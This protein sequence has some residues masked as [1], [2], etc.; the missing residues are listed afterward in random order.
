MMNLHYGCGVS[1]A[2][3]WYNCDGSP[4]LRL[5]H[6]P[7]FGFVFRFLLAPLFPREVHFGN[8]VSGLRLAPESC[9]AAFCS[10]TLEHLTLEDLRVALRNTHRYLKHGGTFRL[11]VPDLEQLMKSYLTNRGPDGVCNFMDYTDLERTT[12]PRNIMEWLR[13]YYGHSQHHWMWDYEGLARELAEIGFIDIRRYNYAER[14][15][16]PFQEVEN[17]EWFGWALAIKCTKP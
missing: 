10:H 7:L 4:T 14:T 5:Q 3:G 8:I 6:L 9:D 17:E 15:V 11:I 13:G 1:F 2:A 16:L 12:C